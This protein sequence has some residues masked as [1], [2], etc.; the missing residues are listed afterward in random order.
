[1]G[2]S[3]DESGLEFGLVCGA[4]EMSNGLGLNKIKNRETREVGLGGFKS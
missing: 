3:A 4:S 1:M 2:V